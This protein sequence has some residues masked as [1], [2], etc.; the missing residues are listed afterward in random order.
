MLTRHLILPQLGGA[1]S[2]ECFS[3]APL[4]MKRRPPCPLVACPSGFTK[5]PPWGFLL[6]G[7][8]QVHLQLHL[9]WPTQEV[10][11]GQIVGDHRRRELCSRCRCRPE[12]GGEA[13]HSIR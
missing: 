7:E 1:G 5:S 2:P 8:R 6:G 9:Q 3:A 12:A 13:H 10:G 11:D 4:S